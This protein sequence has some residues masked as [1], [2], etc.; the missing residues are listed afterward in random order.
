MGNP[1]MINDPPVSL[2]LLCHFVL[3]GGT[4]GFFASRSIGV[5]N[6]EMKGSLEPKL[7]AGTAGG[8]Y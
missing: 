7:N 5:A 4:N 2:S 3:M 6:Q 8:L 1:G